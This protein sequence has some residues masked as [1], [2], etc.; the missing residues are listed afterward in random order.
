MSS[1]SSLHHFCH[2]QFLIQL[3]LHFHYSALVSPFFDHSV[4]FSLFIINLSRFNT[5]VMLYTIWCHLYNLK[6]VKNIHRGVLF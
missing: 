1:L 6:N 5:Y 3:L 2:L 4:I